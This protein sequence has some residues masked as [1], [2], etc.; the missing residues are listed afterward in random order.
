MF[1]V[2]GAGSQAVL[3]ARCVSDAGAYAP[4]ILFR[5][6]DSSQSN[7]V[8]KR[9]DRAVGERVRVIANDTPIW[10]ALAFP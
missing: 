4:A 3:S 6:A 9:S 2:A 1:R 5:W 8:K 7:W 10:P